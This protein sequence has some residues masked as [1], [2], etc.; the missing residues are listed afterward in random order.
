MIRYADKQRDVNI[1]PHSKEIITLKLKKLNAQPSASRLDFTTF[2]ELGNCKKKKQKAKTLLVPSIL[3][4]APLIC[5][6]H[7]N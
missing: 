4:M 1:L 5:E 3:A 7:K 2:G 6:I